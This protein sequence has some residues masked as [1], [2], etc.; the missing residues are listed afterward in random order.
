MFEQNYINL[1]KNAKKKFLAAFDF[2]GKI[3]V[4]QKS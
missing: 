4:K 3:K 2:R 1:I